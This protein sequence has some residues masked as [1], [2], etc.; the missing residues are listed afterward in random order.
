MVVKL[1]SNTKP[2][3]F[4]DLLNLIGGGLDYQEAYLATN[5]IELV[6]AISGIELH[7]HLQIG[8]RIPLAVG[9]AMALSQGKVAPDVVPPLKKAVHTAIGFLMETAKLNTGE[10]TNFEP[11]ALAAQTG[12]KHVGA[13]TL[14]QQGKAKLVSTPA[15]KPPV[16]KGTDPVAKWPYFD[17]QTLKSAPTIKLRDAT[18]MYEPVQGSS[19]NSRYFLVAANQDL[20]IAARYKG[21]SLSVR[22][23]GPS[24]AKH[25]HQIAACGFDNVQ[26]DK[27]YASIHLHVGDPITAS[28]A[29]GA[30][31]LGLGMP[32]ETP[33]PELKMIQNVG[34]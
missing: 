12:S 30:I 20:R 9:P 25:K 1:Q 19:P 16:G 18:R 24:W 34:S 23:E 2:L 27:G 29:L 14:L 17:P 31:L 13:M 21:T 28:K 32:L 8:V 11:F 6:T 22:I 33:L 7:T 4:P 10:F 26:V 3:A 5:P 15:F